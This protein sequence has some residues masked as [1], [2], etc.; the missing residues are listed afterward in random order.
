M[1]KLKACV[2]KQILSKI[3]SEHNITNAYFLIICYY[4]KEEFDEKNILS[5]CYSIEKS[6]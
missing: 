2:V 6:F 4:F 5:A 1:T 3:H